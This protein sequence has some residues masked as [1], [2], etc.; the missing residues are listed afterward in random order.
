MADVHQS[1]KSISDLEKLL[2][3]LVLLAKSGISLGSLSSLFKL[4]AD[5]KA[6]GA[7]VQGVLPELKDLDAAEGGQLLA[8]SYAAFQNVLA[9]YQK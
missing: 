8:A 1:L 5:L 6:F 4:L 3:D 9:A 7:D 2:I